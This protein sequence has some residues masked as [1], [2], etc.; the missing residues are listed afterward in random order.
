[1][2]HGYPEFLVPL[3]EL[4]WPLVQLWCG[5]LELFGE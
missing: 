3:L 1:M 2:G 5:L 4:L